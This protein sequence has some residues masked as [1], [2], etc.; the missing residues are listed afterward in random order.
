M[1]SDGGWIEVVT[2]TEM[3]GRCGGDGY[4]NGGENYGSNGYGEWSSRH[5][6]KKGNLSWQRL[7]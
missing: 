7:L 4:N 1:L 5:V 3:K 6:H 2:A